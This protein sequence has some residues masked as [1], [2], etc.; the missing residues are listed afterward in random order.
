M[1]CRYCM[2]EVKE[3]DVFEVYDDRRDPV[4]VV[5]TGERCVDRFVADAARQA[6]YDR[7]AMERQRRGK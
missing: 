3:E 6:R 2:D 1:K 7:E 4:L 5:C